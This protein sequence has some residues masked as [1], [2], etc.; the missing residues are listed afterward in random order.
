MRL[1]ELINAHRL[2]ASLVLV[3]GSLL[4]GSFLLGSLFIGSS[5]ASAQTTD[6]PNQS[7][8]TQ[9]IRL[10]APTTTVTDQPTYW[11]APVVTDAPVAGEPVSFGVGG[12]E[13]W[14]QQE[15]G[16]RIDA[17]HA[18]F[19]VQDVLQSLTGHSQSDSDLQ[20][21]QSPWWRAHV[22]QS[23]DPDSSVMPVTLDQLIQMALEH[24]AQIR[25]YQKTPQIRKTAVDEAV[26]AFDWNRFLDATWSDISDPVGS[27]LTVGGDG[28]RF[29]DHNLISNIGAR[30]RNTYGG[31][32]ELNQRF[33]HQ[34]T[35]SQFFLPNDQGTARL[36]LGYTQ[37]LMR[38]RGVTYNR[39][40]IV[41]ASIDAKRATDEYQRQ[42]QQHLLEIARAYWTLYLER[43]TLTQKVSLFLK[44]KQ[45]AEQLRHRQAI[46]AQKSQV[47]QATAALESRKSDLI[48]ARAAVKNAETR[49]RALIN[50]PALDESTEIIPLDL[51][52]LEL[53]T[54]ELASEFAT[55]IQNR[56]E[57]NAAIKE[58]R[59]A[60]VRLNMAKHELLPVLNLVTDTYVSGLR[61]ESQVGD[62]WLDQFREGSASYSVGLEY[63]API[64]RRAASAGLQRR[65]L[66]SI[67]L[68]EK[69]RSTLELV[70]A[71]VEVA[72]R[73]VI[74]SHREL[75]AKDRARKA[76]EAEA[77][78]LEAR[79][80][81]LG[82][83]ENNSSLM[84][85]SLIQA[86]QR[87]TQSENDVSK[88][89]L[90]YSLALINLRHANGTLLQM[91]LG[92]ERIGE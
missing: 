67:Q 15:S 56:P 4:F 36:T 85:E 37:P 62:A 61:G 17:H 89:M 66:E 78:T 40:L 18:S 86:Q 63:E 46:D 47:I 6:L 80:R 1:R 30:R 14:G 5:C 27:S 88:A 74:T 28:D 92:H 57:I 42:L 54:P 32:F 26:A 81:N 55:A 69:Y 76:A 16:H 71:E 65:K 58:I 53:F 51:P 33:G 60:S 2:F 23:I 31:E 19:R 70:K 75:S 9:V 44:T 29:N 73:E 25:V 12:Q 13:P 79:W 22:Q 45:N 52:T 87:V 90:T 82:G 48:R 41:L 83:R 38:G 3:Q 39:S 35:N 72:V 84:F 68:S 49:L 34:N 21:L 24:S 43:T 59:S 7:T 20:S 10:P 11:R 50:D 8:G 91:D 64:G 77:E